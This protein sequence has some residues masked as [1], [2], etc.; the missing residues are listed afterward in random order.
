MQTE[1]TDN[2]KSLSP[3]AAEEEPN[4]DPI[5]VESEEYPLNYIVNIYNPSNCTIEI[6]QT[7][8]PGSGDPP[9]SGD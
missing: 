9:P 7:G 3:M 1:Q 2:T 5:M 8:K 4:S 6:K